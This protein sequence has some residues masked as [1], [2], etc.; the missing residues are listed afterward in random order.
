MALTCGRLLN[1]ATSNMRVRVI[2]EAVFQRSPDGVISTGMPFDFQ[3][4]TRYL[5]V[6]SAVEVI[7][8]VEE[9]ATMPAGWRPVEGAGVHVRPLPFYRGLW[10]YLR[11][12]NSVIAALKSAIA[13]DGAIILRVP[14]PL[15][16]CIDRQLSAHGIPYGVEVVG[17]PW[18]VFAPGV[19]KHPLRPLLR[20][21]FRAQ[22]QR[23]CQQASAG[24]YVTNQTL[25]K[26]YPIRRSAPSYAIS[27]V[28]LDD[29][30]YAATPRQPPT[31][32]QPLKLIMVGSLAQLY[33]AP[34]VLIAAVAV[35]SKR[36]MNLHLEILGDGM[37]RSELM[38]LA[39]TLG[40]SNMVHFAGHLASG[41]AV[42]ARLDAADL[43]ILP[44][45]TEG[46]PRAIIEAMARGL[47][48]LGTTVGGIPELL[49]P[50]A[51]VRPG[52]ALALA[53][54]IYE[55]GNDRAWLAQAA[56]R[57]LEVAQRYT[58]PLLRIRRREFYQTVYDITA[59]WMQNQ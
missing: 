39:H 29:Q 13:G 34:D 58:E 3:F 20:H 30:T 24:C 38:T 2:L 36:G 25:Q 54:L 32:G 42:R 16:G 53:N 51:L 57:N 9:V 17:D 43:F 8:R 45:R 41:A 37:Y 28:A 15:A 52:D 7:A 56:A 10:G 4:F 47:P 26:H 27:D 48:C 21:H 55:R 19:I 49:P 11:Q 31:S 22:M 35:C 12:R 50:D 6:F 14:S 5:A 59:T 40:I 23:Q 18:E 33:K 46:L 44:S 1:R